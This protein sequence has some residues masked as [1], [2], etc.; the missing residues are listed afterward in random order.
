MKTLNVPLNGKHWTDFISPSYPKS[1]LI[2][3][4]FECSPSLAMTAD[5]PVILC[6]REHSKNSTKA[7]IHVPESPTGTI[8]TPNS[9]GFAPV[10][11]RSRTN[12]CF[13]VCCNSIFCYNRWW[14]VRSL[15][16]IFQ[17]AKCLLRYFLHSDTERRFRWAGYC[18]CHS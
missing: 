14:I 16:I 9:N 18:M 7:Y 17:L 6:C 11:I 3:E 15:I 4:K 10:T 2:L 5:G 1:C 12:R 8:Y 13:K